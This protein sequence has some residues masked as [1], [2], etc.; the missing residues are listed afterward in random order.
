MAKPSRAHRPESPKLQSWKQCPLPA[1]SPTRLRGT[2]A[3][4]RGGGGG[5]DGEEETPGPRTSH[6]EARAEGATMLF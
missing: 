3:G 6:T 4:L 1:V 5:A 2:A